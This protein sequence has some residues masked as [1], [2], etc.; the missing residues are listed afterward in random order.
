L[1]VAEPLT[2]FVCC[3]V[4]EWM[5]SSAGLAF[6]PHVVTIG[7]GE[8]LA[9]CVHKLYSYSYLFCYHFASRMW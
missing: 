5:N 9:L 7:V 4:G 3:I 8:V 2:S 6:S 1:K